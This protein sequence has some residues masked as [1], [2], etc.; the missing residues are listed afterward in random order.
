MD[1]G[2]LEIQLNSRVRYLRKAHQ[3]VPGHRSPALIQEIV[4][5]YLAVLIVHD[6]EM[7]VGT[8]RIAG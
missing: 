5:V 7:Q 8:R 1:E 2:E 4:R 6:F 3:R